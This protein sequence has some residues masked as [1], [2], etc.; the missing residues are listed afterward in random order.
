LITPFFAPMKRYLFAPMPAS[1][2][3]I[4]CSFV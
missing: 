4:E 2:E 3:I 1:F